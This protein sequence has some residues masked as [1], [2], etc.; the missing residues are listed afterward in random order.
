MGRLVVLG[1]STPFLIDL[2]DE[3]IDVALEDRWELV[4]HGRNED[5]LRL[6]EA[7]ATHRLET[8]RWCVQAT[9]HL[10]AALDGATV[11][12]HQPRYGGTA[13][14]VADERLAECLGVAADETLGPSGLQNAIR[15]APELTKMGTELAKH[16]ADAWI[17]NVTNPLSC[18]TALLSGAGIRRVFGLCEVPRATCVEICDWLGVDSTEVEWHYAGLNHRGFVYGLAYEDRDL[19]DEFCTRFPSGTVGGLPASELADLG[20]V[21]VKHFAVARSGSPSGRAVYVEQVRNDALGQL[22]TDPLARP[23]ALDGR[24]QPWYRDAIV[25][26]LA[27]LMNGPAR[28]EAVNVVSGDIAIE[29]RAEV[30]SSG[31]R[32]ELGPPPPAAV[33]RWIERLREHERLVM[34]AVRTPSSETVVD[35]LAADPL[36]ETDDP[37]A[38]AT[39]ILDQVR[40]REGS[41]RSTP[42]SV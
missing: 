5:A 14:R 30:S 16:C 24:P 32:P 7:Y 3:L 39:M 11:V 2:V 40:S 37:R 17:L 23:S 1:A 36:V 26:M 33:Q 38:A 34:R 12:L 6:V 41:T 9:T 35:A 27:A 21:P 19:L 29:L 20:G 25:P 13:A 18:S 15:S 4:L 42:L 22:R 8:E 28:R 31:V 10:A